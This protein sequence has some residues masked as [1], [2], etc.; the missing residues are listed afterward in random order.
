MK[1]MLSLAATSEAITKENLLPPGCK[2]EAY[3]LH[4]KMTDRYLNIGSHTPVSA[5]A[6]LKKI[7]DYVKLNGGVDVLF[8]LREKSGRLIRA[9]RSYSTANYGDLMQY[10]KGTEQVLKEAPSDKATP[11]GKKVP[12]ARMP[13]MA[14]ANIVPRGFKMT[15]YEIKDVKSGHTLLTR[16]GKDKQEAIRNSIA[17]Y[18]ELMHQIEF[19]LYLEDKQGNEQEQHKRYE[20]DS[21]EAVEI[22]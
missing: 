15:G 18:A 7:K 3:S 20:W 14:A 11:T 2:I 12:K 16:G 6:A 9:R 1:V 4:D 13:A 19:V 5:G 22:Q 10:G 8:D 21:N 17:K